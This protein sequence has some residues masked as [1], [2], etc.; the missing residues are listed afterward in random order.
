MIGR[1][2]GDP[3]FLQ[4]KQAQ[5]SVLEPFLGR[6]EFPQHGQ[7][8]VEGQRLMQAAPDILLGWERIITIDGQ[9][10]DF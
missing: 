8:V 6:S 5:A 7:R 9:E 4:F 10:K 3:L 2:N 1:D